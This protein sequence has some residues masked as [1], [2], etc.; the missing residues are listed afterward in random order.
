MIKCMFPND[1]FKMA[2]QCRDRSFWSS[3]VPN[4]RPSQFKLPHYI[5]LFSQVCFG[6]YHVTDRS[7]M[8]QRYESHL[9]RKISP[10]K[11]SLRSVHRSFDLV[12]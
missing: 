2:S 8:I 3:C 10:I 7:T 5:L 9:L 12:S 1:Y 11:F 4:K 6:N